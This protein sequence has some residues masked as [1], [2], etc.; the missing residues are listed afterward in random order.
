MEHAVEDEWQLPYLDH[1]VKRAIFGMIVHLL[2][3]NNEAQR[4]FVG[5]QL[6]ITSHDVPPHLIAGRLNGTGG[7]ARRMLGSRLAGTFMLISINV[8]IVGQLICSVEVH[9]F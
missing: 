3:F 8:P 6:Q 2:P 1:L 7:C 5:V 9:V 4:V